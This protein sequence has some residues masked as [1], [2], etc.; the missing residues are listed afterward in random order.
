MAGRG[1][2]PRKRF[3]S[4]LTRNAADGGRRAY[5][6]IGEQPRA[7]AADTANAF[8]KRSWW[9]ATSGPGATR[10][11]STLARARKLFVWIAAIAILLPVRLANAWTK[12][13]A[14]PRHG[15]LGTRRC[16]RAHHSLTC[17]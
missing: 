5:L 9:A 4:P 17:P 8:V 13:G 16:G 14:R 6:R 2:A 1:S 7:A 10:P 11:C 12:V 15:R 3:A